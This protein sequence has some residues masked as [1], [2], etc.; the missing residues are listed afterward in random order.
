DKRAFGYWNTET[1]FK[2]ITGL[3]AGI[4]SL[5]WFVG[6]FTL[7]AGVIG[8]SNIMLIVV[9]ER[10]REIGIR[11]AIGATPFAIVSQII[12]ETILLTS[13]SGYLGLVFGII[14][15]EAV[16][17]LLRKFGNKAS[18]FQDPGIDFHIAVIA[19]LVLIVSGAIAGYI[20]AQRAIV[21][22]PVDAIRM[23]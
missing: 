21:L 19:L 23:D 15:L 1:N 17:S 5:I 18:M 3:L 13:I 7:L 8:V 2:K 4:N 11:R 20:P 16:S 10:T 14:G 9:K 22:K 12:M 6:V